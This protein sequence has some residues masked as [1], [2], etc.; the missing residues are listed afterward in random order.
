MNY[1][2]IINET[3]DDF[4]YKSVCQLD[5]HEDVNEYL[6]EVDQANPE[7][8]ADFN[9]KVDD[10]RLKLSQIEELKNDIRSELKELFKDCPDA[11]K[12]KSLVI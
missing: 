3:Q 2:I 11:V 10:I 6:T 9:F 12:I 1:K 4:I 7:A 5:N 8:P